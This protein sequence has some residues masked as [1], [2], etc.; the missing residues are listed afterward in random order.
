M[1]YMGICRH[2]SASRPIDVGVTGIPFVF[3]GMF[4]DELN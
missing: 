1:L 2:V 3:V 4:C